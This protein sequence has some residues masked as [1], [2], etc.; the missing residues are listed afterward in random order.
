[1]HSKQYILL[2]ISFLIGILWVFIAQNWILL[3]IFSGLL[4]QSISVYLTQ[5]SSPSFTVLWFS[6]I[7]AL[8][9]WIVTTL[10]GKPR[11]AAEVRVMQPLW[12]LAASVLVLLGWLYQLIFTVFIWQVQGA[13]PVEG[14]GVN[15][16]ALPFA[17]WLLV[18]GAVMLNVLLLFWLP[19]LLATGRTYRFVVP[20]A[21]RLLGGS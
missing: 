18:L 4:G 2:G 3:N 21:V 10:N 13:S 12:W 9:I 20:G 16:Y 11:N 5:I 17:G 6:C 14:S 15:Y 7:T 8:G 19:T 1:M